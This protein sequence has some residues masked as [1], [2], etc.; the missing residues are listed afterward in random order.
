MKKLLTVRFPDG[1]TI[2][3]E[4]VTDTYIDCLERI[5]LS[6][7]NGLG[8]SARKGSFVNLVSKTPDGSNCTEVGGWYVFRKMGAESMEKCLSNVS[9]RLGLN[10]HIDM[11]TD[12]GFRDK[13]SK[14]KVTLDGAEFCFDKCS[15]TFAEAVR[16]LGDA[17]VENL[18]IQVCGRNL[19][20]RT[21]GEG[22][23]PTSDG[24][25]V[26][27]KTNTAKKVALLEDIAKSLGKNIRVLMR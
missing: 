7:V 27:T 18:G 9:D 8:L 1:S 23:T 17:A 11:K 20:S 12:S 26:W 13:K 4:K 16:R 22:Y 21:S 3:R 15:V 19:I 24:Y 10:L 14:L 25:F 2:C 5:G 6:K